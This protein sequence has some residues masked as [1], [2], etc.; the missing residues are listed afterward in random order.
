[1]ISSEGEQ[2]GRFNLPRSKP[3]TT[4]CTN[5]IG[6]F[7]TEQGPNYP[8]LWP[9][10]VQSFGNFWWWTPRKVEHRKSRRKSKF[11]ILLIGSHFCFWNLLTSL[12]PFPKTCLKHLETWKSPTNYCMPP[13][14]RTQ[15]RS[16]PTAKWHEDSARWDSSCWAASS[17]PPRA[18][19]TGA[20]VLWTGSIP[21]EECTTWDSQ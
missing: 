8:N 16:S 20:A 14:E 1:M 19:Q 5:K 17:M 9:S 12:F 18:M 7:A 3:N 6:W 21:N 2:W 13:W 4:L 10:K 11:A 15:T